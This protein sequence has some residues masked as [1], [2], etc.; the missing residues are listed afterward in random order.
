MFYYYIVKCFYGLYKKSLTLI[1]IFIRFTSMRYVRGNSSR[2]P[3]F[4]VEAYK[5]TLYNLVAFL[6]LIGIFLILLAVYYTLHVFLRPIMWAVLTGTVLYPIKSSLTDLIRRWVRKAD[7]E[8]Q[9][10]VTEFIFIPFYFLNNF[11]LIT[12]ENAKKYSYLLKFSVSCLFVL[13]FLSFFDFFL[14]PVLF[15]KFIVYALI[16]F[17]FLLNYISYK[18]VSS[19]T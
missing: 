16:L 7:A 4:K 14:V 13:R 15:S 12:V 18:M 9:L 19:I 1:V 10:L 6:I 8:N 3:S 11:S 5:Q 17:E 2:M